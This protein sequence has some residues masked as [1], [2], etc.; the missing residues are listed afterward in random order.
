M[1]APP[2]DACTIVEERPFQGR[3]TR[4]EPRGLQPL[5]SMFLIS[6]I[7]IEYVEE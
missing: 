3:V 6:P 4:V 5:W 2:I 7:E 1:C